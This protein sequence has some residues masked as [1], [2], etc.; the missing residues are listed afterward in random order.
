MGRCGKR[1]YPPR[2]RAT[3]WQEPTLWIPSTAYL[4]PGK[5]FKLGHYPLPRLHQFNV[6]PDGLRH[7]LKI[8]CPLLRSAAFIK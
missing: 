7:P 3:L 2:A 6:K 1:P 4:S 8:P 5:T